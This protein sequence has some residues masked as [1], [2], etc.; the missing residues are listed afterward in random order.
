MEKSEAQVKRNDMLKELSVA[1]AATIILEE[2]DGMIFNPYTDNK[3]IDFLTSIIF[4][5][6]TAS[7]NKLQM[8]AK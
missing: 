8:L 1:K 3:Q 6:Q 5:I 7:I 2:L 4:N